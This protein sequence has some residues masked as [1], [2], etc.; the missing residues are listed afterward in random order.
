MKHSTALPIAW[1]T[2]RILVLLNLLGGAAVLALLTAT[3]VAREWTFTA[4]GITGE[5]GIPQMIVGLRAIAALGF[6][7]II[8]N[9][10]NPRRSAPAIR[11][12]PPMP[13]A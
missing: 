12:S 4:L 7:A 3:I 8:L 2:L 11:S 5:S 9:H 1:I 10:F 13:I 6:V